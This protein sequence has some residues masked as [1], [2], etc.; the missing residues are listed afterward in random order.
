VN[1]NGTPQENPAVGEWMMGL[2]RGHVTDPAIG[3]SWREQWKA[4]GNGVCPQQAALALRSL[5]QLAE[6]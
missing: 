3:L 4:V 6:L 1:R 5:L 2:P